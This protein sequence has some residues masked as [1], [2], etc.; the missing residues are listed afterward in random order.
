M[1]ITIVQKSDLKRKK[2]KAT[3]ALILAGGAV[4]GGSFKAGGIKALND[5]FK[6][7]SVNDFDIFIGISSGSLIAAPLVGGMRPESILRS[8]DGTSKHFSQLTAWHYYRPNFEELL[9]R[10]LAFAVRA[11]RWLPVGFAHMLKNRKEWGGSFWEKVIAFVKAPTATHYDAMMK[12]IVENFDAVGFPPLMSLIPS[13]V[14][15]N[16]PIE[17]YIRRNIE[18]NKLTNS[19]KVTQRITG[20]RLYICAVEL[21]GARPVVFGPDE[22][23]EFTISEAVMASTALPGFYRPARIKGVDYVDGMVHE[24]AN[25]DVAVRKGAK[26][27]VCYNP[28]RP[29]DPT[30]FM[31]YIKHERD[32]LS[33]T[34][35]FAVMYQ[36]IRAA[37]HSRLIM[38]VEQFRNDPAF[39]GDIILIEP[40][41]HD[42]DFAT[43]NPFL[44]SNRIHAACMGYESVY[45]SIEDRFDEI[46]KIFKSYG[47]EMSRKG[48]AEYARLFKARETT[49]AR[50]QALLEGRTQKG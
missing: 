47:I 16:R 26:L 35:I 18:R 13:G 6:D 32:L 24:T 19:F 33:R 43:L 5:Y 40:S 39:K 28:F 8:L 50:M 29:Y 20:K 46:R 14:F 11:A 9:A 48:V 45:E 15:D 4:T 44:L 12:P 3:K 30:S 1:G 7:F 23:S 25:I 31:D 34:G 42:A 10:P 27:I 41:A 37:L 22:R 36:I 38:S 17:A 21:D 49:P 2:R